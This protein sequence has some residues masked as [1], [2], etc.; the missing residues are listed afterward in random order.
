MA[1]LLTLEGVSAA[2]VAGETDPGVRRHYIEAF[3][4][5]DIRVLTNYNVLTTGFDAPAVRALYVAR[6]TYSPV[7]YQQMIG[8]GLRGPLNGGKERCLIVNVADNLAQF[9][10]ALAFR[11]FEYL[12]NQG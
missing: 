11:S 6:P 9:G 4:R 3:R 1:A 5:G 8:R 10:E 2:A 7:R 12:W